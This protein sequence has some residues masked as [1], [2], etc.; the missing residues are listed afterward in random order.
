MAT[1]NAPED[2]QSYWLAPY[3][4]EVMFRHRVRNPA[5]FVICF[6]QVIMDLK[7]LSAIVPAKETYLMVAL[8]SNERSGKTAE[9]YRYIF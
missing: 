9:M 5:N 4:N 1:L 2:S 3:L 7:F 8:E 6:E